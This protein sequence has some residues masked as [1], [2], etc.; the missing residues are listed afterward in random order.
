KGESSAP[1]SGD[2]NS[3]NRSSG[4]NFGKGD[5]SAPRSGDYNSTNRSSG[6][7]FGKGDSS[8][9]R[10]GDYN[11]TNR[12][13]GANFGKGDSSAPKR[14]DFNTSTREDNS[15]F[16]KMVGG[17]PREPM[18]GMKYSVDRNTF[19]DDRRITEDDDTFGGICLKCHAKE[20]FAGN[21]KT[22]LIHRTVSGWGENKEHSFPCSK[23]HQT[24]S[25]GLPRL[26][27]TNCFLEGPSGLR[28]NSGLVWLPYKEDTENKD[29]SNLKRAE[30]SK[31]KV[32]GCHVRQFGKTGTGS[33]NKQDGQWKELTPW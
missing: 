26:M 24:H 21:S 22:A 12:S 16:V 2:Y 27:Q 20:S 3:T 13:S 5:S 7:N 9:P 18:K 11:S 10:S 19:G 14:S 1:R 28:E 33:S 6:A 32:V 8:A 29:A 30:T 31:N 23:C 17:S 4:A 15:N 25:S